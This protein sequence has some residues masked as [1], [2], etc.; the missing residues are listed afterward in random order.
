MTTFETLIIVGGG[1]LAYRVYSNSQASNYP[2]VPIDTSGDPTSGDLTG[3]PP[4]NSGIQGLL[5]W[6]E[7][8]GAS[9]PGTSHTTTGTG[10]NGL[11]STG[12]TTPGGTPIGTGSTGSGGT[13]TSGDGTT[14]DPNSGDPT[15]DG[16]DNSGDGSTDYGGDYTDE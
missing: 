11:G 7:G 9:V 10:S 15:G 5:N 4:V 8:G 13:D 1:F 3:N 2:S 12:S 16:T 6:L 14:Y